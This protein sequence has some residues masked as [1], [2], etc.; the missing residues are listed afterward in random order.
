MEENKAELN[1]GAKK[2]ELQ[3]RQPDLQLA[4]RSKKTSA[5]FSMVHSATRQAADL[6]LHFAASDPRGLVYY[7]GGMPLSCPVGGSFTQ[8]CVSV[9]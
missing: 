3:V 7:L 2:A 5:Y 6:V 9:T 8:G 1:V 4:W